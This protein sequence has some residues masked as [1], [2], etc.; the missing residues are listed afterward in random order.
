MQT[1]S[2]PLTL[3][4]A[5]LKEHRL[6]L[7]ESQDRFVRLVKAWIQYPCKLLAIVSG[8]PGTG[9]SYVVKRTLDF[10][11]APQLR[12]SFTARSA[13][14]IGGRTIHSALQL[15]YKGLCRQIEKS[16]ENESDLVAAIDASKKI[17]GEFTYTED[18][19]IV[20]VDEVSMISGWLMYWIVLFF[21]ERTKLPLLF[22]AI[23][24]RH[25]LNPV[26]SPHNLF[27]FDFS[28]KRWLVRS[29]P[30]L[31]N[32]RFTDDYG[33][34]VDQL[35]RFVDTDDE[36][37]MIDYIHQHFPICEDITGSQLAQADRAMAAKN[38][39]VDT[40]NAYYL[41]DMMQGPEIEIQDNLVLK[42]GCIVYVT[43]NGFSTASN[44][45]ELLFTRLCKYK[46]RLI[47]ADPKTRET[48]E[49]RREKASKKFPVVLGFAATI[50]KFQGDTIDNAKIVIHFDGNR[51]LNLMYTALSRVR[52]K[53]QILAVV[54]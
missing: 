50:H 52:H 41:H 5:G 48:V 22:I 45:T 54:L 12:M 14:A 30:L 32:K 36:T 7:T 2:T 42:P 3:D 23:G 47:C 18:P 38:D 49:V 35:R 51:N 43:R 53:A 20:V 17:Q 16:L 39:R 6:S 37:G 10:V 21:M 1:E 4:D 28:E 31:E 8:G 27:S 24:D 19:M 33:D 13:Q 44:G 29:I 40:F 25:Q 11:N 34:L 46:G 9:K 15:N 26:K